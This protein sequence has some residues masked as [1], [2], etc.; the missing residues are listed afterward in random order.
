LP[1]VTRSEEGEEDAMQRAGDAIEEALAARI[2][3]REETPAP[4]EQDRR[5]VRL[6]PLT[7]VKIAFY[8]A[9]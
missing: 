3:R 8:Q 1:G 4:P 2:V 9:A 5:V 6:P 7:T